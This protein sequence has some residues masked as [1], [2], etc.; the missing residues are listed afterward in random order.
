MEFWGVSGGNNSDHHRSAHGLEDADFGYEITY[1]ATWATCFIRTQDCACH[2][3]TLAPI[4]TN[5]IC[6]DLSCSGFLKKDRYSCF[7]T[8]FLF[9]HKKTFLCCFLFLFPCSFQP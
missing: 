6:L 2:F 9:F 5:F 8:S 3:C 1:I 7:K 4:P